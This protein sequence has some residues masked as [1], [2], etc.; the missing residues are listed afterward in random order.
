MTQLRKL[1]DQGVS[2]L[3]VGHDLE[4]FARLCTRAHVLH[5][6]RMVYRRKPR[7]A[8]SWLAFAS[9]DFDQTRMQTFEASSHADAPGQPVAGHEIG[10]DGQA[11]QSPASL[12]GVAEVP[13]EPAPGRGDLPEF[14]LFR[15]GDG[16][17]RIVSCIVRDESR[18]P[19][20][21]IELGRMMTVE[22]VC[23]FHEDRLQHLVGFY[24]KD[25][26]NLN[27]IGLN[28]YQELVQL[29]PVR[30]GDRCSYLRIPGRHPPRL[31]LGLCVHRL[32]PVRAQVDGLHG[33]RRDLSSRRSGPR[34]HGVRGLP[35]SQPHRPGHP[36][37]KGG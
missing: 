32:Q 1:Q 24:I 9:T 13:L 7:E 25:R 27:V 17:A 28:T 31:L 21:S 8:V 23:E 30:A 6:G 2:I 16:T 19:V 33:E 11:P 18:Q 15:Y 3:F 26:L 5:D 29:P 36:L 22:I 35:P 4:A 12:A 20:S 10:A 37:A 14:K 34:P